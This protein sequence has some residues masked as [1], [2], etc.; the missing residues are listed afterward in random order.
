[1]N[2]IEVDSVEEVVTRI[3]T[4]FSQLSTR[5]DGQIIIPF[6]LPPFTKALRTEIAVKVFPNP[7]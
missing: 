5:D 6:A 4:S 2:I 7:K 1:M 3:I